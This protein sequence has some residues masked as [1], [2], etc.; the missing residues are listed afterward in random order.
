MPAAFLSI[1]RVLAHAGVFFWI[2]LGGCRI[3][4]AAP[5]WLETHGHAVGLRVAGWPSGA[6]LIG[7]DRQLWSYP[8]PWSNPWVMQPRL[9]EL[10]AIAAS[11]SAGYALLSDGE[12]ARYAA[13]RWKPYDGSQAWGASEI[14]VTDDDRVLL[15]VA[16][17]LRALERGE[18][19]ALGC[20][21][22]VSVAVAGTHSDVAFVLDRDGALY[23]S[24]PGRCD[25]IEAPARLQRIA[26]RSNRLLAVGVDGSLWRRR[27]GSWTKLPPPFKYRAGQVATATRAQ[28]VGVSAYSSWLVDN[29]GS[30]F[31]LSDET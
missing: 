28:D 10:R 9:H 2:L 17:K 4:S 30:V 6:L 8:G 24:T 12:V 18:L 15:I 25:K 14:G 11:D 31:L 7:S 21:A 29:E 16:G 23:Q 1:R 20:D 22:V 13:G 5:Y 3:Q 26:A 19:K 27:R